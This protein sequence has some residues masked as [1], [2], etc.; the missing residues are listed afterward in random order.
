MDEQP[1]DGSGVM[2]YPKMPLQPN[3][4]DDPGPH[5]RG[6]TGSGGGGGWNKK[7]IVAGLVV[8]GVLGAII[9]FLVRPTHGAEADKAKEEASAAQ[10]VAT[11]E[12]SRAEGLDKQLEALKKDKAD[13]DKKLDDLSNKAADVDKK[14]A[15]LEA[16]EK[17]LGGAI[18]KSTGSVSTEGD[19][20]H[21]KLVDKVL[22]PTGED[23]LT[24]K[25]KQVLDKVAAALKEFPDK[26]IYVQGHT[27][28][29]PIYVPAKKPEPKTKP[30]TKGGKAAAPVKKPEDEEPDWIRYHTNWELAAAR[31]LEVVHYLQDK[32]KVDPTRL[33]AVAFG[34][35]RPVSRKDLAANRRIEIVLYPRKAIISK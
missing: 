1:E 15:D 24:D 28:N 23:Q 22:F 9:G 13:E 12:K 11:A 16:A 7:R 32:D 31:A 4:P 29:Q 30:P 27:D 34:Q 14:A 17:K 26:Q 18:D 21:L 20:I 8:C 33:A 2:V 10:M 6:F 19:E 3:R 25:G 35:W 5:V